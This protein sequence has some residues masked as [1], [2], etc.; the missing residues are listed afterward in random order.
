VV[1]KVVYIVH[2]KPFKLF[3]KRSRLNVPREPLISFYIE[4]GREDSKDF[5]EIIRFWN[6]S[7]ETLK[8]DADCAEIVNV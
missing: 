4:I 8:V 1:N 7:Y 2:A 5:S 6:L 3:Y